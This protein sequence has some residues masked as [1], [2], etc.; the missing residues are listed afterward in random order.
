MI[1]LLSSFWGLQRQGIK[2]QLLYD[3][4]TILYSLVTD[5]F[6]TELL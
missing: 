6:F 5:F 3:K 2:E 4:A 1:E